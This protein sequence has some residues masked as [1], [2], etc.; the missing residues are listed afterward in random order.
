LIQELRQADCVEGKTVPHNDLGNLSVL[1]WLVYI[2]S[3]S[4]RESQGIK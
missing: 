4:A 1:G 2:N 3:H